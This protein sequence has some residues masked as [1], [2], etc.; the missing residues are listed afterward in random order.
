[1]FPRDERFEFVK[2]E[3]PNVWLSFTKGGGGTF[4]GGDGKMKLA[5]GHSLASKFPE[6]VASKEEMTEREAKLAAK[7]A[8]KGEDNAKGGRYS[9]NQVLNGI[10]KAELLDQDAFAR[11]IDKYRGSANKTV[12]S[13]EDKYSGLY[14]GRLRT[15]DR[16]KDLQGQVSKESERKATLAGRRA[17]KR[18]SASNPYGLSGDGRSENKGSEKLRNLDRTLSNTQDRLRRIDSQ[19]NKTQNQITR[20]SEIYGTDRFFDVSE[21]AARRAYYKLYPD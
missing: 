7:L 15:L 17:A 14:E 2:L 13:L 19:L 16:I 5:P 1:M 6:K 9:P 18:R 10:E 11:E 20:M 12:A 4:K 8:G 21:R 3:F